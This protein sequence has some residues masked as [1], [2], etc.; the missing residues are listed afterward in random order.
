MELNIKTLGSQDT[1]STTDVK[2]MRLDDDAAAMVFQMFSKTIYSN[3][4]GTVVREITSN[5]VDSHIEAGINLPVLIKRSI[6]GETGTHYISFID[7]GV[8]MSPERIEEVY[9]TF[10]K[11]TK[12]ADNSQIGGFGIG[13]KTPLAYKRS[14]GYGE[15][16]YDNSYQI[17]TAF[18]GMKYSYLV[19]EGKET[20]L[21]ALQHTEPTKEHNG[22]EIRIPVLE[23]DMETF[24]KEMVKQ[25]YY[26]ENV[27]FE[28]FENEWRYSEVLTNDYSIIRGKNFLYRGND[29][30][31]A[32]H[33]CLGRVAYPINYDLL[34][35]NSSDYYLPIAVK[36]EIG[37]ISVTASR[38][39]LDYSETTIK[40]LKKKLAEAKAEI[41]ELIAKQYANIVTLEDYF[42]VKHEFGKLEFP[43]GM[44]MSV[45]SLIKQADVDFSNFRYNFMKMPNDRQLFKFFFEVKS[46]GKKPSR[47]RYSSK[48]EFEGGYRELGE[49]G[50]I[51]YVDGEFNRKVVKQAY[52]KSK[53]DLYH[54]IMCRDITGGFIRTEIA[55]LFNVHVDST[56]DANGK[57]ITYVQSLIDMQEEYFTIVQQY[58]KD[59]D[60]IEVPEDF[61]ANRKRKNGMS[62]DVRNTTI[63]VKYLGYYG[64]RRT[65]LDD[66]FKLNTPIF[67][68]TQENESALSKAYEMYKALFDEKAIGYYDEYSKK[69]TTGY[70][71]HSYRK[72][73]GN[74]S[75]K[76]KILFIVLSTANVKYMEYCKKAYKPE[77][78]GWRMLYRKENIVRSYFQTF[79]IK[80]TWDNVDVMYRIESFSKVNATWGK[81]IKEVSA[82]IESLPTSKG[83]TDIGYLKEQLGK[84]F[85]LTDT[86]MTAE[87][88]RISKLIGEIK[89]LES[90]NRDVLEHICLP[91]DREIKGTLV[92]ILK[93]VM[94]F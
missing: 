90:K 30:N 9:M 60:S 49:S 4:I 5:A 82:F 78:F 77:E 26:F 80:N 70:D 44:T 66:L 91:Y 93:K 72:T 73:S 56:V 24:A 13:G 71:N 55:E 57:P 61:I 64:K 16:E 54:I 37:E 8:G 36:V 59:Y 25:L 11:S 50:N 83:K 20:P 10:F 74:T 46:Y 48:Y 23:K 28:G 62:Q 92:D 53:H 21:V 35:L 87:Q 42:K 81:K 67:Y 22:T 29:V 63:P 17:I 15:G 75:P 79:D 86:G 43:N 3:P 18:N 76:S 65:K 94:V 89:G 27:I 1:Q 34:N 6:D 2:K 85:D 69:F 33:V 41:A 52:L 7:Y 68:A 32:M 38:E 47:S 84:F 40:V 45:S 31:S 58:A 12:R 14:T 88:K 51:L 39:Q 19:Y